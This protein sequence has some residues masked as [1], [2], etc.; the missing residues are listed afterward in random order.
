MPRFVPIKYLSDP[1]PKTGRI[2]HYHY[3]NEP[4][5]NPA[6]FAT[7]WSFEALITWATGGTIPGDGGAELKPEG[8]LFEDLGPKRTMGDGVKDAPRMEEMVKERVSGG[9]PFFVPK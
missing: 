9:C 1:D 3:L 5:Y 4:W 2:K 6:T 7:R 8:F